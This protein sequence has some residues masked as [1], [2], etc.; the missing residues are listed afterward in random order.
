MNIMRI[1]I[2][3]VHS[4]NYEEYL[5]SILKDAVDRQLISDVPIGLLLS[6]VWTPWA[7]FQ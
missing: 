3:I 1:V 4:E 7:Y 5:Y 2:L 6:Q